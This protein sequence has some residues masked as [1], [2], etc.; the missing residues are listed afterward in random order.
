MTGSREE[1]ACT[2]RPGAGPLG[3]HLLGGAQRAAP[4]P[5]ARLRRRRRARVRGLG[6]LWGPPSPFPD[7]KAP[8]TLLNPGILLA[9]LRPQLGFPIPAQWAPQPRG[10]CRFN[11]SPGRSRALLGTARA[12]SSACARPPV[13]RP[14]L[15]PQLALPGRAPA[16]GAATAA[17]PGA[18]VC[19]PP[20]GDPARG[21]GSPERAPDLPC[22]R[23]TL[24]G[25][26]VPLHSSEPLRE[27]CCDEVRAGEEGGEGGDARGGMCP[28]GGRG[29][30]VQVCRTWRGPAGRESQDHVLFVPLRRREVPGP[31]RPS[32]GWTGGQGPHGF[33]ERPGRGPV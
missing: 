28:A 8:V 15:P 3:S 23:L 26:F 20:P 32:I 19:R 16:A 24:P 4:P 22:S 31:G 6:P 12:R 7:L 10:H 17:A 27:P 5:W 11:S 21:G 18:R 9:L 29:A 30:G 33:P 1:P 14:S 13:P 25:K 2:A